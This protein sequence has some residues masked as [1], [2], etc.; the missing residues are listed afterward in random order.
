MRAWIGWAVVAVVG[1]V[2]LTQLIGWTDLRVIVVAQSL[3]PYLGMLLVPVALLALWR[4]NL[5]L[6]T[7]SAAIGLAVLILAAPLAFPDS[8]PD[9]IPDAVGLRIASLNLLYRNERIEEVADELQELAPDVIVFSEYTPE[10]QAALQRHPLA[11]DYLYRIDRS[12]LRGGGIA[13]WSR[14]SVEV[15]EHPETSR[16]SID[17]SVVG[18]DGPVRVVAM[19]V[20]TPIDDLSGWHHDFEVA[21]QIGRTADSPTVLIGDLNASH[22]H[23]DY[24]RV[25]DAGFVDAHSA[26]DQGFSASWPTNRFFPPFVRLDHALTTGGLVATDVDDFEIPGSDH[27]GFVVT[28]APTA[29]ATP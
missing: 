5:I 21:E 12:A 2:L 23:P 1:V 26:D 10:H 22:W 24:R 20:P 29:P 28:V 14:T 16:S 8:Q 13:V 11:K 19:H 6:A 17:S 25:L 27:R 7:V 18:P 3:T 9:P 4:R 15:G